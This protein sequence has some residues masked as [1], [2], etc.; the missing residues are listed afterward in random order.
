MHH[1]RPQRLARRPHRGTLPTHSPPPPRLHL[2]LYPRGRHNRHGP[3]L[4]RHD[5]HAGLLLSLLCR[6]ASLDKQYLVET[7]E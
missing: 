2:R 6:R 4:R 3:P 1:R 7:G 5:A